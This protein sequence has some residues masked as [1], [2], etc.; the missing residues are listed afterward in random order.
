MFEIIIF[1][2]TVTTQILYNHK[3]CYIVNILLCIIIWQNTVFA[4]QIYM[5]KDLE[6]TATIS[7]VTRVIDHVE[8]LPDYMPGETPVV[9]VGNLSENEYLNRGRDGFRD[10][11]LLPGLGADYSITYNGTAI[12]YISAYLNYPLLWGDASLYEHQPE[13]QDMPMFPHNVS[14]KMIDGTAVVKLS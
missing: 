4:N 5:K 2:E 3:K 14:I 7:L 9:L 11:L 13:V 1:S 12:S 6:K 10:L 8:M